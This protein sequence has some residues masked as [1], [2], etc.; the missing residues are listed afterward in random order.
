[1][2]KNSDFS[3]QVTLTFK[4]DV[5]KQYADSVLVGELLQL[6]CKSSL[7]SVDFYS[8]IGSNLKYH[9]HG[10]IICNT[11]HD[12]TYVKS[13]L[14]RW[15]KRY[16]FVYRSHGDDKGWTQ[17]IAKDGYASYS[18]HVTNDKLKTLATAVDKLVGP[19]KTLENYG[20]VSSW[21]AD[22]SK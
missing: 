7:L 18:I 2:S 22:L 19:D 11:F 15:K 10:L 17:Y 13:F 16:G 3:F 14:F 5:D 21:E 4:R 9:F 12:I 20:F 6:Y 1:M 8:E